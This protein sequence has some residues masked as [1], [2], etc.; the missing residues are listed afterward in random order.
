MRST[1]YAT[2]ESPFHTQIDVHRHN[3]L[4]ADAKVPLFFPFG[5][6]DRQSAKGRVKDPFDVFTSKGWDWRN[7]CRTETPEQTK[8]WWEEVKGDLTKDWKRRHREAI[9]SRRR[10]GGNDGGD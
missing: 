9:K 5:P 2:E 7:F 4:S 3:T 8:Q 1:A 6:D 10:R